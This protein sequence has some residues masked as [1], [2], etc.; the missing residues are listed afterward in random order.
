MVSDFANQMHTFMAEFNAQQPAH[1]T[2]AEKLS[3]IH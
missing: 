2:T 3:E 1:K